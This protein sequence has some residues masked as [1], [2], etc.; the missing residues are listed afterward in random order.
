MYRF[1]RLAHAVMFD[2]RG[3]LYRPLRKFYA[4]L[5][6]RF[7]RLARFF[8]WHERMFKTAAFK[9][10]DCGDCSLAD[11]Q[12]MCPESAC[13]KNMRNG[14]C[15][16]SRGPLCEVE[17]VPCIWYR[18]YHRAKKSGELDG[19]LKGDLILRDPSLHGSS[20][21][22]N[23]FLGRDHA[24][25]AYENAGGGKPGAETTGREAG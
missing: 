22:S 16:G 18:A 17:D 15:G 14:P 1:N 11:C 2:P 6:G 20:S 25:A 9:C 23:F 19:F 3:L 7:P 4:T 24:A 13:S 5:D 12:Y 21:W 8:E 10:R